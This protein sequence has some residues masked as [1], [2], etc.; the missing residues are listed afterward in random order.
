M[1]IYL[2]QHGPNLSKDKDPEEPL[3]PE[4]EVLVSKAAQAIRKMGL[5]FDVII[6]SPK[7]RS[8]QTAAMVAEAV[9]FPVEGIVET[10]QVKAMT[11]AENTILYLKQ[12]EDKKAVLVAGH[13]PSLAE[14]ASSLLTSGS[15]ATIQF[16]RGGIGRIDVDSLP[17]SKGKLRWYLIPAQLELMAK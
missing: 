4:G 5:N 15:R 10:E 2:M 13:L 1:E 12:F 3:S 7:K 9:G 8:K 11:P 6:A 17:T 16:E 14:V